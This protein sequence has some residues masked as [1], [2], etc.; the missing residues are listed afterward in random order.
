[1]CRKPLFLVRLW[2]TIAG[3]IKLILPVTELVSVREAKPAPVKL[4]GANSL[5]MI[6]GPAVSVGGITA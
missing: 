3:I 2:S 5:D 6:G 1:M 4:G